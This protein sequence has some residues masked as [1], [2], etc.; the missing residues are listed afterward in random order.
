MVIYVLE[1]YPPI[2][3]PII[4][5]HPTID[6]LEF[7][8]LCETLG[9]CTVSEDKELYNIIGWDVRFVDLHIHYMGDGRCLTTGVPISLII[10]F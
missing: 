7:Q 2:W 1:W 6:E 4:E 10:T 3:F 5:Y 9:I 8:I